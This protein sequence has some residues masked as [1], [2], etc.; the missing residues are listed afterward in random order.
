MLIKRKQKGEKIMKKKLVAFALACTCAFSATACGNAVT[1]EA[2]LK[3]DIMA[4]QMKEVNDL[5]AS[6][7]LSLDMY[8]EGKDVLTYEIK[9][10]DQQD[11]GELTADD[12]K[13]A[14]DGQF[15]GA[16]DPTFAAVEQ[17]GIKLSSIHILVKNADGTEIYSNYVSSSNN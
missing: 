17:E 3:S 2:V 14:F 9:Y 1:L 16:L 5:Y 4:S 12:L 10:L 11:F 6:M 15:E 13:A 7:G 8:A